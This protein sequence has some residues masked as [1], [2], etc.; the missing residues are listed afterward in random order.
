MLSMLLSPICPARVKAEL[1]AKRASSSAMDPSE[2][3]GRR[4]VKAPAREHLPVED[5]PSVGGDAAENA[6]EPS[7]GGAAKPS[8]H[9]VFGPG[10][11]LEKCMMGGFDRATVTADYEL[12]AD[13]CERSYGEFLLGFTRVPIRF[14]P[15]ASAPKAT[16]RE[17]AT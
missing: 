16:H 2:T 3:K 5:D 10:G 15:R 7:P 9:E 14:Q 13:A 11:F 8:M 6:L 12:V 4:A 1:L 17:H